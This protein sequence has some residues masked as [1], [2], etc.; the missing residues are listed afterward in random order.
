MYFSVNPL[1]AVVHIAN[2]DKKK[3]QSHKRQ[4]CLFHIKNLTLFV[5]STHFA[6]L[7]NEIKEKYTVIL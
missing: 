3:I 1:W 6:V 5:F 4:W 2:V 7:N